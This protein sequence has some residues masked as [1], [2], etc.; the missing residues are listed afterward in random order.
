MMDYFEDEL[1]DQLIN[2]LVT[3]LIAWALWGWIDEH[4]NF[5][6]FFIMAGVVGMFFDLEAFSR[7]PRPK[8]VLLSGL[9]SPFWIVLRLWVKKYVH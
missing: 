6:R 8:I 7:P 9:I 2:I 4:T 1:L 3:M 5:I